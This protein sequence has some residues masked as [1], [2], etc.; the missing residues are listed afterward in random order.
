MANWS[1]GSRIVIQIPLL[2]TQGLGEACKRL[3]WL[4]YLRCILHGHLVSYLDAVIYFNPFD[5][6]GD[7]QKVCLSRIISF[8]LVNNFLK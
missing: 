4:S 7:L 5:L 2:H 1:Q 8:V 3:N 6:Q